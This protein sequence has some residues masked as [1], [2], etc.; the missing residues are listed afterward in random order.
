MA[1]VRDAQDVGLLEACNRAVERG[2]RTSENDEKGAVEGANQ[3][4]EPRAG[5]PKA[6]RVYS[7][8]DSR[9]LDIGLGSEFM[10]KLDRSKG[11]SLGIDVTHT[12]GV[13]LLVENITVGLVLE[14][15]CKNAE[16]RV[17]AGDRVV[18]V[19]GVRGNVTKM[20]QECR[21]HQELSLTFLRAPLGDFSVVLYKGEDRRLGVDVDHSNGAYLRVESISSGVVKDWNAAHPDRAVRVGDCIIEV[22]NRRGLRPMIAQCMASPELRLLIRRTLVHPVERLHRPKPAPQTQMV[23]DGDS[24]VINMEPERPNPSALRREV[25]EDAES[26]QTLNIDAIDVRVLDP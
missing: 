6:P 8:L 18:E 15:N 20:L 2:G 4:A 11:D 24:V 1:L 7:S 14:Y 19:N 12:D 5:Q 13:S 17:L 23:S 21:Q 3:V 22:N 10:V 16:K 25:Q 26:S 9:A